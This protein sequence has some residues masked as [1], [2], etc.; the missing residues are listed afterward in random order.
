MEKNQR[1]SGSGGGSSSRQARIMEPAPT[2]TTNLTQKAAS[3]N[4]VPHSKSGDPCLICKS[5]GH[6]PSRCPQAFCERCNKLGHLASV[7][8]E[9]LPWECIAPMCAFQARGQGFYYIHDYYSAAHARERSCN[10]IIT[11]LKGNPTV[12]EMNDAFFL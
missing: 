11:V 12:K 2:T 1:S 10:V 8:V 7:C 5:M 6:L 3:K 4:Q 9:F